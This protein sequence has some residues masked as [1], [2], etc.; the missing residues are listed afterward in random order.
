M[1]KTLILTAI[2]VI[3][4]FLAEAIG[5]GYLLHPQKWVILGFFA[6]SAFLFSRIMELGFRENRKNF[7][8]FYLTTVVLRLLLSIIF[9]GV[10]LYRG[11]KQ[12]ELFVGNFFVLYLFYT[13]F[14]IWNLNSNLRRN[15]EK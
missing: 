8:Q 7:I 11:L 1:S 15:S 2:L 13:I 5:L 9:I 10:E 14:E 12:Q 4:F 6:A 3:V